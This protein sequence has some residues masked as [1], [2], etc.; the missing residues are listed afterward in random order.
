MAE[1][2]GRAEQSSEWLTGKGGSL[3]WPGLGS[4]VR[5]LSDDVDV[6]TSSDWVSSVSELK[7]ERMTL[8]GR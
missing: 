1:A 4:S 7:M 5:P 2:G 6:S 3:V 8:T